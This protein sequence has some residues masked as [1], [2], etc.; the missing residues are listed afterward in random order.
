M[1]TKH[2]P[3]QAER[4]LA[5]IQRLKYCPICRKSDCYCWD[6]VFRAI[7]S[8]QPLLDACKAA[9]ALLY[10][11]HL[12]LMCDD[13]MRKQFK[14]VGDPLAAAIKLAEEEA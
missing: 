5:A 14:R 10:S 11:E 8:H 7:N 12:T 6:E 9:L 1:T 4:T 13:D 3:T 2:T